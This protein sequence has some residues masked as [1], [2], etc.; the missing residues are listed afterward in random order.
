MDFGTT[1]AYVAILVLVVLNA[2]LVRRMKVV[3]RDDERD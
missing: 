3:V 2:F 1:M